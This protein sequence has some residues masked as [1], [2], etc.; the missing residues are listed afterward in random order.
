MDP[1]NNLPST[2]I[3]P[4]PTFEVGAP[5]AVAGE[6]LQGVPTPPATPPAAMPTFLPPTVPVQPP[7]PASALQD[8]S[9]PRAV[10]N[11]AS[12]STAHDA[13]LIEKEWVM[14]AKAIVEKNKSDPYKQTKE[15]HALKADYMKK[16]YNK[17]IEE[18][19]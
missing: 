12:P 14:R 1:Q 5:G 4:R 15:L 8:N 10:E 16:R 3:S 6:P 2:P 13:D 19:E 7:Q 9:G 11:H 17:V 18:A